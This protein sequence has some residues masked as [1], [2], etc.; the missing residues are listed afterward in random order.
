MSLPK[1]KVKI[2]KSLS[3]QGFVSLVV[4]GLAFLVAAALRLT[5]PTVEKKEVETFYP[6]VE[7]MTAE[8]SEIPLIITAF[9]TVQADRELTVQTE[10]SGRIVEQSEQL[11]VGGFFQKGEVM[12]EIDPRDYEII[13]EQEKAAVEKAEFEIQVEEGR[14]VIA[15]REWELLD[16]SIKTSGFGKDLAL[17][18][19]HLREKQAALAA[20]KSRLAKA[21]LDLRRTALLAPFDAI[22]LKEIVE[23][24][25]LVTTQKEIATIAATDRFRVQVSIPL[26]Q[27]EWITIP[28]GG[29]DEGSLAIVVQDIGAGKV[30]VREG[31][32]VR[33]VGDVDPKSRMARVF[34][35]IDD[36]LGIKNPQFRHEPFLIG[37]YVR[38]EIKGP[39]LTDVFVIPREAVREGD[40]VW[41]K[42]DDDELE[43]RFVNVMHRRATAVI[44]DRGLEAGDQIIMSQLPDAISGM[45]LKVKSGGP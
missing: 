4:V 31:R 18:K 24:G 10:V 1:R 38:V 36:P 16:P 7:V 23:L 29:F 33:L 37:I 20:A 40:Q 28:S 22:V 6:L 42:N 9:G 34:V 21:E 11:V 27:L 43:V 8:K 15:K 25:E 45:K 44:V 14:Q 5:G 32:V 35:T 2:N 30:R 41:I 19:P 39:M 3:H 26:H 13:V 12:L 17:R